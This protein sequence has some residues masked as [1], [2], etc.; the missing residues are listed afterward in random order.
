MEKIKNLSPWEIFDLWETD[1]GTM[2]F[3]D[4]YDRDQ[5]RFRVHLHDARTG[6]D[7]TSTAYMDGAFFFQMPRAEYKDWTRKAVH[8]PQYAKSGLKAMPE[9]RER[10]D[11]YAHPIRYVMDELYYD[12][13]ASIE[14]AN[15]MEML[16]KQAWLSFP[17]AI[18]SHL[19]PDEDSLL[20]WVPD[21]LVMHYDVP[22]VRK[23]EEWFWHELTD[24]F[25]DGDLD[26]FLF[27]KAGRF[28]ARA[29]I[30]MQEYIVS[31]LS[32]DEMENMVK[33][34]KKVGATPRY[35]GAEI[36]IQGVLFISPDEI[37]SAWRSAQEDN[38]IFPG[39]GKIIDKFE[40]IP[41]G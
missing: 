28:A 29:G 2:D 22:A 35:M 10:L 25:G 14:S 24:H 36:Q 33:S 23:I 27:A 26:D 13:T 6:F 7:H 4:M 8:D 38:D 9:V 5:L 41:H 20:A 1:A 3:A 31:T 11:M 34:L 32:E 21:A 18:A 19:D 16:G 17:D 15:A 39:A 12:M 40:V 30:K 37:R